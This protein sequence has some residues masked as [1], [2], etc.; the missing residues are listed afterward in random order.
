MFI[1]TKQMFPDFSFPYSLLSISIFD[2]ESS[3]ELEGCC[4]FCLL[5]QYRY[6]GRRLVGMQCCLDFQGVQ[7]F[8]YSAWLL[9]PPSHIVDC[10]QVITLF[11]GCYCCVLLLIPRSHVVDCVQIITLFCGCCCSLIGFSVS[12]LSVSFFIV[13]ICYT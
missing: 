13:L 9:I 7:P 3:P 6:Q 5:M 1:F 12:P 2:S 11:C 8:S 4:C 10:V